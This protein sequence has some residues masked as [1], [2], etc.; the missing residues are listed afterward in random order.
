MPRAKRKS[1]ASKIDSTSKKRGSKRR[2]RRQQDVIDEKPEETYVTEDDEEGY[3]AEELDEEP[4]EE[5]IERFMSNALSQEL[6]SEIYV[7]CPSCG[8][9]VG[10]TIDS[11]ECPVCGEDLTEELNAVIRGDEDLLMDMDEDEE[12]YF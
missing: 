11:P 9:V 12:G 5:E 2:G 8:T 6:E 4:D 1:S 7:R 3:E 10:V